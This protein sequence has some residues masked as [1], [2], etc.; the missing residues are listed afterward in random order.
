MRKFPVLL[1]S[2]FFFSIFFST[3]QAKQELLYTGDEFL[4]TVP[5]YDVVT[6]EVP[7][8]VTSKAYPREKL[9]LKTVKAS[10]KT[11]VYLLLEDKASLSLSCRDRTYSFKLNPVDTRPKKK[12]LCKN[13]KCQIA[14]EKPKIDF[15]KLETHFVV[16]DPT[17]VSE[18][19][20]KA[21][22]SFSSKEQ[23]VDE[24]VK[25]LSAMVEGKKAPGY[26]VRKKPLTYYLTADIS[27]SLQRF[28][29]GLLYGQVVKLK[30]N[31]YFPVSF[32]VKKLDGN[33][34]VLLYSPS[35]DKEGVIH[36]APG[37]EALLYVVQ[38]RKG[39]KLPYVQAVETEAA[40]KND[41]KA[42]LI[43]VKGLNR[44]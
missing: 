3:S 23:I 6:V 2:L 18:E 29:K 43:P 21:D 15:S 5:A 16:I 17:V 36:F 26:V 1:I 39:L 40:G 7:C 31:S 8:E 24:A 20:K 28:Y 30:N 10:D 25:L 33:G 11:I 13:G 9:Q 34:N 22:S 41:F 44:D 35:M 32:D 12:L 37:S 38:V 27:V 42:K 14:L 19:T 4:L